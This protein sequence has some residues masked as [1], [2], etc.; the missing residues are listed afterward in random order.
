MAAGAVRWSEQLF[1]RLSVLFLFFFSYLFFSNAKFVWNRWHSYT[2]RRSIESSHRKVREQR[3]D[4]DR[5][6]ATGVCCPIC[7]FCFDKKKYWDPLIFIFSPSEKKRNLNPTAAMNYGTPTLFDAQSRNDR[8]CVAICWDGD[9]PIVVSPPSR[10]FLQKMFPS[11]YL[12]RLLIKNSDAQ[13][14]P[15]PTDGNFSLFSPIGANLSGLAIT[16]YLIPCRSI[17]HP[18][19]AG[20]QQLSVDHLN[21]RNPWVHSI[22]WVDQHVPFSPFVWRSSHTN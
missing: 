21:E 20:Q 1:G 18:S 14:I 19:F 15:R 9:L 3:R 7:R 6:F 5:W 10:S 12:R 8:R 4:R 11:F 2:S 22:H 13:L 16:T 17:M